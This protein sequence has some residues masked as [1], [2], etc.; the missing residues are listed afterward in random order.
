METKIMEFHVIYGRGNNTIKQFSE[1]LKKKSE[2]LSLLA[3]EIE[4]RFNQL[5]AATNSALSE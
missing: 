5:P 4:S 1:F 3:R 2:Q